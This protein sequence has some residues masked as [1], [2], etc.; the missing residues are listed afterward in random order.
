MIQVFKN[1]RNMFCHITVSRLTGERKNVQQNTQIT[2]AHTCTHTNYQVIVNRNPCV[3]GLEGASW[4]KA[5]GRR[6]AL[7]WALADGGPSLGGSSLGGREAWGSH[8]SA[9]RESNA[10]CFWC[11]GDVP[12]GMAGGPRPSYLQRSFK[13]RRLCRTFSCAWWGSWLLLEYELLN[14]RFFW[15]S[16]SW[17]LLDVHKEHT[18]LNESFKSL[19]TV[20]FEESVMYLNVNGRQ[21][22]QT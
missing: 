20:K 11:F 4:A 16:K 22:I 3:W 1:Q 7:C 19:L 18:A 14:D 5:F 12:T 21:F 9:H 8:V 6:R 13:A 2:H 15:K 17:L 10:P